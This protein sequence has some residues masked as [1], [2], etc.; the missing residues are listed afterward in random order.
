VLFDNCEIWTYGKSR[1]IVTVD[2]RV[3]N[4]RYKTFHDAQ[5]FGDMVPSYTFS[6][7]FFI[8]FEIDKEEKLEFSLTAVEFKNITEGDVGKLSYQGNRFLAFER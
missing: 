1:P 6:T 7:S 2:A 3:V 8:T 4:K 5:V